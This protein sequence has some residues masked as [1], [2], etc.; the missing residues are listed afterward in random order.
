MSAIP[1][2]ISKISDEVLVARAQAGCNDSTNQ[3]VQSYQRLVH[4]MSQRFFLPGADRQDVVQEAMVG[5]AHAIRSF[6]TSFERKFFDYAVMCIRNSLVRAIR[7]ANRKKQQIL[8]QA[9]EMT[10]LT[11]VPTVS[12][13]DETVLNRMALQE[14]LRVLASKLSPLEIEVLRKRLAG[15]VA[16]EMAV[17]LNLSIK[18]IENALFR[19]RQKSRELLTL[20]NLAA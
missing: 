9:G 10:E 7:G 17:S 13:V 6:D 12:G 14:T 19:A 3:I 1:S 16:E 15:E 20:G 11:P 18:Q 4:K 5:L 8:N 2:S